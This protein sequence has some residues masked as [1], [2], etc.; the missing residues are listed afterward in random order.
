MNTMKKIISLF[1]III[2]LSGCN[3]FDKRKRRNE[4]KDSIQTVRLEKL[5][6]YNNSMAEVAKTFIIKQRI[7][8][9]SIKKNEEETFLKSEA[10]KI[11]IK[12]NEWSKEDC[13]KIAWG[14]VW[15]GMNYDML[16]YERGRPDDLNKSNYGSGN[17][18]QACW[19]DYK[20]SCVYYKSDY[21]IYSYN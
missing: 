3:Y 9:D 19:N 5:Q 16:R 1:I 6:K 21:I 2:V 10:G 14:E 18:Y 13:E 12:H 11:W 20:P 7:K 17:E 4:L 15:I 8:Q